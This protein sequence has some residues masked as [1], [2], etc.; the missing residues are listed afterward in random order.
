MSFQ[1]GVPLLVGSAIRGGKTNKEKKKVG[2]FR[3]RVNAHVKLAAMRLHNS[4]VS[5]NKTA[6]LASIPEE[7]SCA[8][9]ATFQRQSA[10][11]KKPFTS[12][13]AHA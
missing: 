9:R 4:V 11:G 2:A 13:S 8:A 7:L 1:G 10:C 5:Q 12:T 3:D 6:V